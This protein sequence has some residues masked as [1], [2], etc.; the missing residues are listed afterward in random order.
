M[1]YSGFEIDRIYRQQDGLQAG[2][3]RQSENPFFKFFPRNYKQRTNSRTRS[4]FE[5]QKIPQCG[6]K[7]GM[8]AVEE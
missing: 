7:G 6:L 8:D 1:V 4:V 3:R 5:T 2:R